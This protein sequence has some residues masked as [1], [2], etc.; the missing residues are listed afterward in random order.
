MLENV[1]SG[2]LNYQNVI[3]IRHPFSNMPIF[4]YIKLIIQKI[5]LSQLLLWLLLQVAFDANVIPPHV[6]ILQHAS[7]MSGRRLPG[8]STMWLLEDLGPYKVQYFPFSWFLPIMILKGITCS[9]CKYMFFIGFILL[10][11]HVFV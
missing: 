1:L 9:I 7:L 5:V 10:H 6:Q 2:H 8:S 11:T 4:I 3:D